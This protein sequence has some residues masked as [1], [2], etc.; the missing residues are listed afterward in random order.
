MP[1]RMHLVQELSVGTVATV[2]YQEGVEEDLS[3][4]V[5]VTELCCHVVAD[6]ATEVLGA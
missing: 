3:L 5:V 2:T 1:G 4:V 6:H